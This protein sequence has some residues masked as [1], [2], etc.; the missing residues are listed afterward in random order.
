MR[1]QPDAV[2]DSRTAIDAGLAVGVPIVGVL[3]DA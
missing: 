2:Q 3:L 1:S